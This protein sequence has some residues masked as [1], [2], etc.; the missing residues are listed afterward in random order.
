M[1]FTNLNMIEFSNKIIECIH[2]IETFHKGHSIVF[3]VEGIIIICMKCGPAGSSRCLSCLQ[4]SILNNSCSTKHN[5]Q[6]F[7]F[8]IWI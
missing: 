6:L 1:D 7:V 8:F 4:K 2:E 5:F 3:L